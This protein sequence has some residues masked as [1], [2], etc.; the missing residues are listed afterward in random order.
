M[1]VRKSIKNNIISLKKKSK[2]PT[3][4]KVSKEPNL[5]EKY[6][7]SPQKNGFDS[8]YA[9]SAFIVLALV[10]ELKKK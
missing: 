5:Y 3:C 4:K 8:N 9:G 7:T 6:N 1:E 2:C 10:N